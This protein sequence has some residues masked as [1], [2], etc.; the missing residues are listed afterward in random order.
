MSAAAGVW[1]HAQL[2]LVQPGWPGGKGARW[3]A[4]TAAGE[5]FRC[6]DLIHGLDRLGADGWELVAFAP[7]Q[8]DRATSFFFRRRCDAA[9]ARPT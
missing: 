7:E 1:A 4:T 3:V 2:R 8:G 5:Q 9:T 6:V